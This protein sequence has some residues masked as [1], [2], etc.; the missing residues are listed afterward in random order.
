[1]FDVRSGT[2]EQF[3]PG[4]GLLIPR[5]IDGGQQLNGY[6]PNRS[7]EALIECHSKCLG[8]RFKFTQ[9][10]GSTSQFKMANGTSLLSPQQE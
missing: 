7:C 8:G 9:G 3:M 6:P 5:L 2:S 10:H 1:M 4:F